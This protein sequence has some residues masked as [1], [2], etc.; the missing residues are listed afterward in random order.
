MAKTL[1]VYLAADL[2]KFNSGMDQAGKKAQGLS[3]TMNKMLGPAL[4]GAGVAAGAFATKLAVDG[5]KAAIDNEKAMASL[6]TTM[7][8]LGVAHDFQAVE[9]YVYQLERAYGVADT[10]LRPAYER[11]LRATRD[12]TQAQDLLKLSMDISAG[13]GKD[14]KTVTEALGKAFEGT[15]TG[16]SRLGG[17]IDKATLATGDMNE[18]TQMLADTFDGQADAAAKTFG[19]QLQRLQTAVDNLGEAFGTGLIGN[20]EDTEDRTQ[21][22]VEAMEDLEPIIYLL[23]E[24]AATTAESLGKVITPLTDLATGA[25]AAED[26]TSWLSKSIDYMVNDFPLFWNGLKTVGAQFDRYSDSADD[27]TEATVELRSATVLAGIAAGENTAYFQ[28]L[29]PA[30]EDLGKRT[31]EA[32][33]GYQNLYQGMADVAQL[34]RDLAGT[35]GTVAGALASGYLNPETVP[36]MNKYNERSDRKNARKEERRRERE[37]EARRA[38]LDNYDPPNTAV[39]DQDRD[40]RAKARGVKTRTGGR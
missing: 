26:E 25:Q 18:I 40:A 4:I 7:E 33:K 39:K 12:A 23:G 37:A 15:T 29:T 34:Q 2:K 1:T 14:L 13:T 11:L 9:D 19:G 36:L 10:D 3:G 5:V 38:R 22:L 6:A 31:A 35:S 24:R 28:D 16:L 8:N 32:A 27:A 20:I 21:G 17:G 30:M